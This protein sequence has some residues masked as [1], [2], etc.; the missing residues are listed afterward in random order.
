MKI[1]CIQINKIFLIK[2]K[3]KKKRCYHLIISFNKTKFKKFKIEK[4]K[5]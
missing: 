3:K 2:K 5:N 4:N 1:S